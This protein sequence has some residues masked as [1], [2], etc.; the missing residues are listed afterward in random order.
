MSF[1]KKVYKFIF[2]RKARF[3]FLNSL[4]IYRHLSDENFVKLAYKSR[5][6]KKINLDNPKSFNEKIQWLKL[7]DRN[8]C[9]TMMVDK[10]L[11]KDYVASKIGKEYVVPTI[12]SW[13]SVNDIDFE[14]L[15]DKFVLKC[16]HNSGRGMC[17][18]DDKSD[19]NFDMVKEKLQEGICEDYYI[20]AREWPYKNVNRRILAEKYMEDDNIEK[21]FGETGT[22]GLID[23]KFYCFNGVP[24]FF[25]IGYA[26]IKDGCKRDLISYYTLDWKEAPF[27]RTD[28]Q[29][30][31]ASPKKPKCFEKMIDLAKTLSENIPFV[32]VDFFLIQDKIYFSEFTFSPGAGFGVF[33]P[34]EWEETLGDWIEL[35]Q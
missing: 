7:Y 25:Y 11:V 24:K 8:P 22:H 5:V 15:P 10:L 31:E 29:R 32:R 6:G 14:K 16:N 4:G 20:K 18:C 34:D 2:S 1:A 27:Y 13:K 23:Y 3:E 9:Y 30:L 19:L 17:I 26:N 28:H 21:Y 12:D 33:S 35:P